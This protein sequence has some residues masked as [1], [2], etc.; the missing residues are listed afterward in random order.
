MSGNYTYEADTRPTLDG[1]YRMTDDARDSLLDNPLRQNISSSGDVNGA[2]FNADFLTAD[3]FIRVP[4]RLNASR[5]SANLVAKLDV[6][7]NEKTQ[8]TFGATGAVQLNNEFDRGLFDELGEQQPTL[9]P[10]LARLREV[11]SAVRGRRG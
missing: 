1:V 5:Q 3:D 9:P 7:T 8:L 11:L 10:R 6:A 2:L 4:T